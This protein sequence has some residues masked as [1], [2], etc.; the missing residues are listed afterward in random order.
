MGFGTS[1]C[2]RRLDNLGGHS[3]RGDSQLCVPA[4]QQVCLYR[5]NRSEKSSLPAQDIASVK[6]FCQDLILSSGM[7]KPVKLRD[8]D[9]GLF[10][11]VNEAID[12]RE[13]VADIQ[14]VSAAEVFAPLREH[15]GYFLLHKLGRS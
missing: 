3:D 11:A 7:G 13:V 15:A 9:G 5:C 10:A 4:S 6:Q 8:T 12:H 14:R 1:R 2:L